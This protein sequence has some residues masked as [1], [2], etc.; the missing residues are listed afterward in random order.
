MCVCLCVRKQLTYP[1][2]SFVCGSEMEAGILKVCE[3]KG[4]EY[5]GGEKREGERN[6]MEYLGGGRRERTG[7]NLGRVLGLGEGVM[8]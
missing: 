7:K 5:L 1:N 6:K 8:G 3:R 2:I 4:I